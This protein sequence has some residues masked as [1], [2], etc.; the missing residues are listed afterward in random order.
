MEKE[1]HIKIPKGYQINK[2]KSNSETIVLE[3]IE[4]QSPK[5][6]KELKTISGYFVEPDCKIEETGC[7]LTTFDHHR[8]V[9]FTKEQAEASI[10]LAQL[11]QL[12]EVYRQGWY[13]NWKATTYRK[14]CIV[15]EADIIA[16]QSH[17]TLSYFLSFQSQEIAEEFLNNF[18]YLIEK[19]NPLLS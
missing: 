17:S 10:A 1:Q 16:I 15:N 2:E 14:F 11:S 8:N 12:R 13:P 7:G 5:T 18:K 4:P 3:L 9:F 19:A 6:W